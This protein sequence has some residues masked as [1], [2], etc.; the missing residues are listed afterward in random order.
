MFIMTARELAAAIKK[1]SIGV[2]ELT[3]AYLERIERYDGSDGLNSI[4]ELNEKVID[5]AKKMD[6]ARSNRD[7]A[8]FGL[9]SELP[10]PKLA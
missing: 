1:K 3:R 10:L 7:G 2:E 4:A 9:R 5:E 6:S 8:M